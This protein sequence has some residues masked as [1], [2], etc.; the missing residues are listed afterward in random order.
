MATYRACSPYFGKCEDNTIEK[1]KTI[2]NAVPIGKMVEAT[3]KPNI[4]EATLYADDGVAEQVKIFDYADV[5]LGI[6]ELSLEAAKDMYGWNAESDFSDGTLIVEKDDAQPNYGTYGHIHG[7]IKNGKRSYVVTMLHRVIFELPEEKVTTMGESLTFSTP[8]ITG[9]AYKDS[10][11][12]WRSRCFDI[13]TLE[14]AKII[15][16]KLEKRDATTL[17]SASITDGDVVVETSM[18]EAT[19]PKEE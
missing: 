2:K 3:I 18:K 15:L 4:K 14:Q 17:S 1:S 11:G 13:E 19:N 6:D 16:E 7:V 10:A 12:E 9:K 8:S 5:T